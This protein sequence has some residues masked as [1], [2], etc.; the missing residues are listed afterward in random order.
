MQ[1]LTHCPACGHPASDNDPL[2]E[3]TSGEF[4]EMTIHL[5]HLDDPRSGFY[6]FPG[7]RA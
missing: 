1:Q 2:M 7:R 5:S 4:A 3:I 6:Q